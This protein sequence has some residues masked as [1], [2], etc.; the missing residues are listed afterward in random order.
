MKNCIVCHKFI[1]Q[2]KYCPK[3]EP[4]AARQRFIQNLLNRQ[5]QSQGLFSGGLS[6]QTLN[7]QLGLQAQQFGGLG[8]SLQDQLGAQQFGQ[9]Q[10][11]PIVPIPSSPSIGPDLARWLKS[12]LAELSWVLNPVTKL[13]VKLG[14]LKMKE[15]DEVEE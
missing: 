2:P 10:P 1:K 5:A 7:T 14:F 4:S 6:Q 11:G 3:H 12:L 15:P 8:G 9:S 13:G